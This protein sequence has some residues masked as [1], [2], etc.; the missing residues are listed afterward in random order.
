QAGGGPGSL[1]TNLRQPNKTEHVMS[2][3][4]GLITTNTWQ[5]VAL[6]YDKSSN[7]GKITIY[8]NGN[9][10]RQITNAGGFTPQTTYPLNFGARLAQ[11]AAYYA[12]SMDE[13]EIFNRALSQSEIQAI[14]NA[15]A[16]GKCKPGATP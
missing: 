4:P 6:T 8:L 1:Y 3:T 15:G 9:I 12:G 2:T 5:H 14:F 16:A 11:G 13:V 7:N 10:A